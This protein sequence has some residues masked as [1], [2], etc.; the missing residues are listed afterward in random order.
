MVFD[1]GVSGLGF[2]FGEL[3]LRVCG[4]GFNAWGLLVGGVFWDCVVW[5]LWWF[6]WILAGVVSGF[7]AYGGF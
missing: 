4:L 1:L 7:I 6:V 3:L 2:C 5:W